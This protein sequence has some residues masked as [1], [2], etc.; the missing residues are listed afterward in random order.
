MRSVTRILLSPCMPSMGSHLSPTPA[1]RS[2]VL[3]RV[4]KE[5]R[6]ADCCWNMTLPVEGSEGLYLI[7][8]NR[9]RVAY[10]EPW[11]PSPSACE[12]TLP[13]YA[14]D[15]VTVDWLCIAV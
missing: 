3:S 8:M 4:E 9:C 2:S 12:P 5:A 11:K 14:K 13:A 6:K 1:M 7:L 10:M 15:L